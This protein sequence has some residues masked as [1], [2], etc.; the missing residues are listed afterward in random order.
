MRNGYK[1]SCFISKFINL[2]GLFTA[3]LVDSPNFYYQSEVSL[4]A[5]VRLDIYNDADKYQTDM[6]NNA[7]GGKNCRGNR[8]PLSL[9]ENDSDDAKSQRCSN[10]E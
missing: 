10:R 3:L 9:V 4:K 1:K 7:S 5:S 2:T 6:E 8:E